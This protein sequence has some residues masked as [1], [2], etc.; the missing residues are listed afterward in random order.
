MMG[1]V[2]MI[3]RVRITITYLASKADG[4]NYTKVIKIMRNKRMIMMVND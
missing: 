3:G 2:L 4:D 1:A